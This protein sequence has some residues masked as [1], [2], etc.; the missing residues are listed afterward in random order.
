M[1]A[2]HG[3]PVKGA[4]PGFFANATH[5]CQ[6]LAGRVDD[7]GG[8]FGVF[9]TNDGG[10]VFRGAEELLQISLHIQIHCGVNP[11]STA[12]NLVEGIAFFHPLVLHQIGYHFIDDMVHKIAGGLGGRGFMGVSVHKVE[13]G[14]HCL[15]IL[16]LGDHPLTEHLRKNVNL[17]FL[18]SSGFR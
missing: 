6:Q 16:L 10:E 14:I 3:G 17:A 2:G 1:P 15:I 5:H 13:L 12:V 11:V 4:L 8:R 7:D 9:F 18:C